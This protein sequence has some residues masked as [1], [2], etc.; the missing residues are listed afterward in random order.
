[1][2]IV[3]YHNPRC[4]KSRATLQLLQDRGVNPT[5]IE[6]LVNPPNKET[7]LKILSLLMLQP[8]QLMRRT[9]SIYQELGLDNPSLTH[10]FQ[11][12]DG[13]RY[14]FV[15]PENSVYTVNKDAYAALCNG[16]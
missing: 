2:E 7:L 3:I 11:H 10:L 6:Y 4:S 5:V 9:E 8:R 12:R 1:M 15:L 16:G 13:D 14:A